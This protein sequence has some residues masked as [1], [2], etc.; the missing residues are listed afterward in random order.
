MNKPVLTTP[1]GVITAWLVESS[2]MANTPDLMKAP[3]L[4]ALRRKVQAIAD[5]KPYRRGVPPMGQI[6]FRYEV[7]DQDCVTIVHCYFVNKH[8]DQKRFMRLK[9]SDLAI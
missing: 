1:A 2:H 3:T 5:S 9:R 4:R 8:G 7:D 6:Q